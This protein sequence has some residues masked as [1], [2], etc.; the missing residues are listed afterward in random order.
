MGKMVG[1]QKEKRKQRRQMK[2]KGQNGK[3]A[4]GEKGGQIFPCENG[5]RQN[6]RRKEVALWN[7]TAVTLCL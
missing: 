7:V 3:G 2:V 5:R 4:K 1:K 6:K